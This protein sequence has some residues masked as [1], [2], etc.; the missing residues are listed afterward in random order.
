MTQVEQKLRCHL[1]S[2]LTACEADEA[3]A[4]R[5]MPGAMARFSSNLSECYPFAVLC[6]TNKTQSKVSL[7]A[8]AHTND[9]SN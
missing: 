7:C 4:C 5:H 1:T 2:V 9:L 6:T 8:S 3:F